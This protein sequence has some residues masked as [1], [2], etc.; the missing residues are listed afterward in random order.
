MK[1]EATLNCQMI[2]TESFY[3]VYQVVEGSYHRLWYMGVQVV[4]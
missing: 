1:V 2:E 4:I 3:N